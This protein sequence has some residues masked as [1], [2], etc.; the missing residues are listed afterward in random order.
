MINRNVHQDKKEILQPNFFPVDDFSSLE[1]YEIMRLPVIHLPENPCHSKRKK[2]VIR[3]EIL[4]CSCSQG[5]IFIYLFQKQKW[6]SFY[7][8]I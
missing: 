2:T 5:S 3:L 7:V 4:V 1:V 8:K 6:L